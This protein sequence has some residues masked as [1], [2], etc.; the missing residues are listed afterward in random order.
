MCATLSGRATLTGDM[1]GRGP[2]GLEIMALLR[3]RFLRYRAW[4]K[5]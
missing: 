2:Y 4:E 5:G 1:V 3:P